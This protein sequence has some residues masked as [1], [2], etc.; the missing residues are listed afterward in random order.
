MKI[1]LINNLYKPYNRGGAEVYVEKLSK[2]FS[3]IGYEVF[4]IS[5]KPFNGKL[6]E[7]KNDH[8]LNSFYYNLNKLPKFIRFFWHV[9]NIFNIVKYFQV[10]KIL[11][12]EKP[13]LVITNNLL[14]L[15]FLLPKLFSR[16]KIKHLHVLHDIQLLHPSGLVFLGYEKVLDSCFSKFYQ[17][18]NS[19]LFR[20]VD[21]VIS[22]SSWLL[23][24]H[25]N[26]GFFSKTKTRKI[27]NPFDLNSLSIE[28]NKSELIN[29]LYVGQLEKH[30]GVVVV[31]D[32]MNEIV[33]SEPKVCFS[34]VGNGSLF[35]ELSGKYKHQRINFFGKLEKQAVLEKMINS[36]CLLAPSLCYENSPTVIYEAVSC[37]LDFIFA[38]FG[39]AS[40]IGKHFNGIPFNPQNKD[41]LRSAIF[42]IIKKEETE[43]RQNKKMPDL[44]TEGY[45]N[46]L[47]EFLEFTQKNS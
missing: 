35:D 43:Y 2:G 45:I 13:D 15:S 24:K 32:I 7:N 19:Y 14:G 21:F 41:S 34:V 39:G 12:K 16:K 10:K 20:D 40:E 26:R 22:P 6:V 28:K 36:D 47:L 3:D 29:F 44:S 27:Y 11:K 46:N 33:V 30:K 17:K 18:I 5:T 8:Y 4:V 25:Q 37:N 31:L 42:S 9:F 38:D 1:C 23:K